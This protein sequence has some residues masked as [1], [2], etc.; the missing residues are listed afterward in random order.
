MTRSG[1]SP[2]A[3]AAL[4]VG[5]VTNLF[6]LEPAQWKYRARVTIE[7][8]TGE[9]CSLMLTPDVYNAARSDLGDIRLLDARGEQIPYVLAKPADI[10]EKR[11]YEPTLINRSEGS[12]RAAVV[13]LDFGDKTLKNSIEVITQGDNFRRAV[14]VEGSNDNI[15]FFTL[16]ERAYVFAVSYDK[17]FEQVDLP[18]SDYRYLRISVSPMEAEQNSPVIDRIKAFK[19]E[20]SVAERRA[21]EMVPVEHS[22]DEEKR[23]S[24][25]VYD[26]AYR[27][28]PIREIE[29]DVT[30]ESFYRYVTIE[31]RDAATQKVQVRSEDNRQR[32]REVEVPWQRIIGE[33]IYR[34]TVADGKTR[35]NLL[36][37]IPSGRRVH[38]YVRIT[39][40]NYDDRP[41]SVKSASAN[42]IAH[43]MVFA[44]AGNQA[45]VLYVGSESARKP[46]YDLGRRLGDPLRIKARTAMLG[47]LLDN[48][49]FAEAD[50][51]P[52]AWTERHK[53]LLLIVLV[54]AA[55]VL[56]GF[57]LKSFKSI[58][59]Q[60]VHN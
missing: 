8:G 16:V 18:A 58:R 43:R 21:V 6:A 41:L 14:K 20:Q 60:E 10:A 36:L 48:P 7:A 30:D 26:L 54:A 37:E 56:A 59:G 28:L 1:V 22:E 45:P 25:H 13:T 12:A 27:S 31:G 55:L 19:I 52:A 24:I 5:M 17:R 23:S 53:V 38:R 39:I 32:F 47:G 57:I 2:A 4:V 29:L 42:M 50:Q 49:L 44:S 11:T 15:E 51:G 33:A 40:S 9:Y 34:Y 3:L 46:Q 35:E